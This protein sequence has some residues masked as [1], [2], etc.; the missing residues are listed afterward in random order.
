M[1]R[2]KQEGKKEF[3]IDP[4]ELHLNVKEEIQE[5]NDWTGLKIYS[6]KIII[7]NLPPER[8]NIYY[9]VNERIAKALSKRV[10]QLS[11]S[12]DLIREWPSTKEC[13]RNGFNQGAVA[14]CCR[15]EQKTHK[16]FRWMFADD[17][18]EKFGDI[19]LF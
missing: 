17:Y 4:E 15:G 6:R 5:I 9:V 1:F 10:I 18:K 16:G 2:I 7:E 12:G 3:I 11:L 13:G 19:P 14:A 8:K